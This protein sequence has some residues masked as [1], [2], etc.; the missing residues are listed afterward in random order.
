MRRKMPEIDEF[1]IEIPV[2]L[3]AISGFWI[4][5]RKSVD[6]NTRI[7]QNILRKG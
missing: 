1:L 7:F 6:L 5:K 3:S 4:F 2:F